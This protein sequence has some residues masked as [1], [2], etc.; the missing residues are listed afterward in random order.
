MADE[1][2]ASDE[3]LVLRA[4]AGDETAFEALC[5]RHSARLLARIGARVTGALRRKVGASD[6]LQEAYLVALRRLREFEDRGDGSFGRW[7]AQIVEWKVQE[8]LKRYVGAAK[9]GLAREESRDTRA[10]E[11]GARDPSPSDAAIAGELRSAAQAA[12]ARLPEAH[13]E[14]LRLIQEEHLTVAE[15]ALRMGRTHEAVRKLYSRALAH[16][17]ELLNAGGDY[18]QNGSGR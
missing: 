13:R 10:Q 12:L 7:L 16:F 8:T 5:A 2:E 6:V 14:V 15:A 11:L 17:A 4:Q 18:G 3:Q 1:G 9:R